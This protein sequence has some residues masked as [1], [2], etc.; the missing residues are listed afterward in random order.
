MPDERPE[1]TQPTG[2]TEHLQT[3]EYWRKLY[4]HAVEEGQHQIELRDRY[5]VALE[6][7]ANGDAVSVGAR[8]MAR[9]AL[10]GGAGDHGE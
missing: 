5:R 9:E 10:A 1:P 7:I 8:K 6:R 3:V 4:G 2:P